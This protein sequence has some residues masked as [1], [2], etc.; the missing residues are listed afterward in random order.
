M[1]KPQGQTPLIQQA[2]GMGLRALDGRFML[3]EQ[4]IAAQ[5]YWALGL[6]GASAMR[7]VVGL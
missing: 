1:V 5:A 2:Q 3:V 4:A 6:Q 7:R